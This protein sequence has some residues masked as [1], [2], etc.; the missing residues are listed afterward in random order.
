MFDWIAN[1]TALPNLHPAL[2]HF[3]IALF[4]MA[5]LLDLGSLLFKR[6]VWLD[7]AAVFLYATGWLGALVTY[8]AGRQ[9]ADSVGMVSPDAQ[10]VM[11]TH[12]DWALYTLLFF[13]LVTGLRIF[14]MRKQSAENQIQSTPLRLA[15]FVLAIVGIGLLMRTAD[16]GGA[17]VYQHG[18]AVN[19]GAPA[20]TPPQT[21]IP[22]AKTRLKR[23]ANG[24]LQWQPLA[25]DT[26]AIGEFWLPFAADS[27]ARLTPVYRPVP[28][29]LALA[30]EGESF[31]LTPDS[32]LNVQVEAVLD[33]SEFQGEFGLAYRW[34]TAQ[35]TGLFA[36]STGANARLLER[37]NPKTRALDSGKFAFGPGPI[38]I[39]AS[40][41]GSHLKGFV[42][43]KQVVHGHTKPAGPGR[44]GLWF[45]G[46]GT[47]RVLSVTITPI[48][49]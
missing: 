30:V 14:V 4:M 43:G 35:L 19:L 41:A 45:N 32:S 49:K 13:F 17:L 22:S 38:R 46:R 3:P 25:S 40:V 8:F 26:N 44:A 20:A 23:A 48:Q 42:N 37:R 28:Q 12:S 36:L 9:A 39:A 10:L 29:G 33:L 16:L 7:N 6:Q 2:V 18:V 34:Q 27:M 5:V 21:A 1:L 24:G 47:V 15:V 31:L 11:A